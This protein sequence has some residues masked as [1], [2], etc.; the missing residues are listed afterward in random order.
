M[1][2]ELDYPGGYT[3][4]GLAGIERTLLWSE[5]NLREPRTN[6]LEGDG[7]G[8][9]APNSPQTRSGCASSLP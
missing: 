8:N 4:G 2:T 7:I 5:E 1:E 3:H 6:C 9:E